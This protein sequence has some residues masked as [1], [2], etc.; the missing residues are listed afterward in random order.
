[1]GK[2]EKRR[3]LGKRKRK[4]TPL[5]VKTLGNARKG[6]KRNGTEKRM[7]IKEGK[8]WG[9]RGSGKDPRSAKGD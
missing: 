2:R 5:T 6:S 9:E 3:T 1:V 8:S 7:A 4:K